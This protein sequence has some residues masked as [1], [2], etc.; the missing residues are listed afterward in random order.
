PL[1]TSSIANQQQQQPTVHLPPSVTAAMAGAVAAAAAAKANGFV[2]K[3]NKPYRCQVP[4]CGKAYKNPNGLKYHNQHGHCNTA[5][6]A[7]NAY[8]PYKCQVPDCG[9]AYKNL[10]GLKYH[11]QHAH[12]TT[13]PPTNMV[14]TVT[15]ASSKA[16]STV[17]SCSAVY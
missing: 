5:S 8:K 1:S 12:F 7:Q 17:K 2:P 9:K 16:S 11:V 13:I 3:E 14:T 10:N 4:G 15:A 6:D